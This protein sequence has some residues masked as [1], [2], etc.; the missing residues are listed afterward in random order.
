MSNLK[1][2]LAVLVTGALAAYT[3]GIF[4]V[5]ESFTLR[6]AAVNGV[7]A[8]IEN[9]IAGYKEQQKRKVDAMVEK[10]AKKLEECLVF[11]PL[12]AP[13]E[14]PTWGERWF[15][16]GARETPAETTEGASA[17]STRGERQ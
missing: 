14:K 8:E 3:V 16:R 12:D 2:A 15:N 13:G 9:E 4:L 10:R 11:Q 7:V 1:K 5:H 17:E 6:M